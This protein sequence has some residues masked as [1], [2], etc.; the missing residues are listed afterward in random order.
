MKTGET[1]ENILEQEGEGVKFSEA[2]KEYILDEKMQLKAVKLKNGIEIDSEQIHR[3][4]EPKHPLL[5]TPAGVRNILDQFFL[6][7]FKEKRFC[8]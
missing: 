7:E 8:I 6:H 3:Q 1:M 4:F 5:A 2:I